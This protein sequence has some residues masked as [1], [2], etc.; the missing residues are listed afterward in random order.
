MIYLDNILLWDENRAPT[1]FPQVAIDTT[2][3]G[4][5][6]AG[7]WIVVGPYRIR[8]IVENDK[9]GLKLSDTSGNVLA[10]A[11]SGCVFFD[12]TM[13]EVQSS[14]AGALSGRVRGCFDFSW[15]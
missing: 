6:A 14:G 7:D 9:N 2:K 1:R 12:D 4:I 5:D 15:S 10:A 8:V 11:R 3:A 13:F